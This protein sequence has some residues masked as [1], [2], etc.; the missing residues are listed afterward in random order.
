MHVGVCT[1]ELRMREPHSLKAKRQV[2]K[3]IITRVRNQFNVAVAEV[4]H[5]DK[6]QRT[7]LGVAVVS[8]ATDHANGILSKVVN[9]IESMYVVDLIDYHIEIW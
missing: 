8:T 6:W 5:Q 9:F 4:D 7:T 1:I 3:S 2:V